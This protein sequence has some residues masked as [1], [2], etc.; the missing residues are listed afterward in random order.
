MTAVATKAERKQRRELDD[1]FRLRKIERLTVDQWADTYRFLASSVSAM[2]GRFVT[3]RTEIA[4]GIM[5]A[6]TM[7][8]VETIS[9]K[10][11]TQ[12]AKTTICENILGYV[13]HQK[14]API[15]LA[16]P[17]LDMAKSF[18][19][20]RLAP[21]VRATPVLKDI[22]GDVTKDKS[23]QSLDY[24]AF[25]G[26]F[27]ALVSAGTASD[28]AMRPIKITIADEVDKMD[29]LK[30]EGDPLLLLEERTSTFTN[31]LHVRC[32]SPTIEGTSRIDNSYKESDQRRPFVQCPHCDHWQSWDFWKHVQWHKSD[33]G[34]EHS[35]Q[36]ASLV[37]E[38][39]SE[40]ITEDQR[41]KIITTEGAIR[42][43]QCRAFTC[44]GVEQD[45]T[46]TRNWEWSD[47]DQCG[48]ATC[49]ECGNR[50]VSH[51]HAGF[52][53]SKLFSPNATVVGLAETWIKSKDD[54][55]QR[56][57]FYNT[58]L[59]EA[60]SAHAGKQIARHMLDERLEKFGDKLPIGILRI[61][62]GVD[63]QQDRIEALAVGWGH[64]EECWI[65]QHRILNGDPAQRDVWDQLDR[66]ILGRWPSEWGVALGA[67]ATCVDTGHHTEAAYNFC[68]ARAHYPVWGI[69]GSSWSRRG[70]PVWPVSKPQK[71]RQTGFKPVI[72]A[73]DSAKDHMRAMLAV[74]T[75]GPG[76]VH[77]G[78]ENTRAFLDQL[79]AEQCVFEK[80]GGRTIRKWVL[81]RGRA[82]EAWDMLNYAYAALCGLKATRGLD[83]AKFAEQLPKIVGKHGG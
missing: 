50:A 38:S 53:A 19:K 12:I 30:S 80:K 6:A 10:L 21:M 51:K 11:C 45:P 33:D 41:R 42:W 83:M 58:A 15:L 1:A 46:V 79:T 62:I 22:L 48:Y 27:V 9:A 54:L 32:C 72:L 55:S 7:P 39:C 40:R 25:P 37:C 13:I 74:D 16:F 47:A 63:V 69:K 52:T 66:F 64:P 68:K 23:E 34:K 65:I 49:S 43:Q 60:F 18:S 3:S 44:C 75:V 5:R 36:T 24:K 61:T 29:D 31:G 77:I 67:T 26:G 70:D 76:F 71:F 59:G 78:E 2:P 20:E 81:P 4:R 56:Q 73:V 28:L 35:P 14:P 8:G 17:K 57:V 82:N